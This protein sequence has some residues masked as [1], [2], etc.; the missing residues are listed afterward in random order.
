MEMVRRVYLG[1]NFE[2]RRK[3]WSFKKSGH[4]QFKSNQYSTFFSPFTKTTRKKNYSH[5]NMQ[6]LAISIV[7]VIS[8]LPLIQVILSVIAK[9]PIFGYLLLYGEIIIKQSKIITEFFFLKII[10][11]VPLAWP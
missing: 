4:I 11:M 6:L 7:N 2:L 10:L 3:N 5:S 8:T 1:Q 9:Q